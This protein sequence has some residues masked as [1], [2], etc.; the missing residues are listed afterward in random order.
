[1]IESPVL[2]LAARG[3][4][5]TA[6]GRH[7]AL[8]APGDVALNDGTV[9]PG[10][11]RTD[12]PCR[13]F[14]RCGGCQL[15]HVD[16]AAYREFLIDRVAGALQAQK[17]GCPDIRAPHLSPPFSRR[18][19]TM[20]AERL[21]GRV[22]LGFNEAASHHIID[23]KQCP[24]LLPE[25]FA[26]VEPL[27]PL[28]RPLLAARRPAEIGLSRV[29]QG[30]AVSLSG[31]TVE[32]LAAQEALTAFAQQHGLA[33]LSVDEGF[34][35]E[36]RWEPEPATVTLGGTAVGVPSGAFLQA[37]TDGEAALQAAVMAAVGNGST[38]IDLF[39]GLGTF[40][41]PLA[42][43]GARILAA[44]GA[45]DPAM[46]LQMAARRDRLAV[47]VE[48]R[49]L[50]RRP[51]DGKELARFDAVVLDPPRAGAKEQMG[52]LAEWPGERIAYASCNPATFARDVAMLA[53]G[54]WRIAW[55]Q[56]IGQFR[57]STHVEL[58]AALTR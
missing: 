49:D 53:S 6:D 8:A 47:I 28:L 16:D 22:V 10:P 44:E 39:S 57:W 13:H 5:V 55:V 31:V 21:G 58:V 3:D 45:R 17:L 42:R 35:L 56:P 46:A 15:Q 29:D 7:V 32:G 9:V 38:V 1:V 40:A 4:G 25:L 33:Q 2:R 26:L 36:T 20:R 34:G 11:H 48:H 14:P 19:A 30:V 52:A 54:G 27:R 41:L 18:R 37:T 43:R 23:L 24:I 12:P 50:F 51:Y